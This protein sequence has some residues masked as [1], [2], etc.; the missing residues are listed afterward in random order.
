VKEAET[1]DT[2]IRGRALIAPGNHHLLLQGSG[3]RY[4]VEVKDGPL[5][6]I[7]GAMLP[8]AP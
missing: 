6:S 8:L 2:V 4:C 7:A 5:G 3:A 1:N